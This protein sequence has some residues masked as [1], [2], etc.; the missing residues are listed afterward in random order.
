MAA[1]DIYS[2]NGQDYEMIIRLY[3]SVNDVKL[4]NTAWED[5]F[6][7]EDIFDWK[8][9]GSITIKSP[10]ESFERE[11]RQTSNVI[12]IPKE[13]LVYKFRNDGRDTIFITIKPVLP[14]NAPV[15]IGNFTDKMWRL[16]IEGVIYDVEDLP[17]ENSTEK[18]KKLY[19]HEK[20]YQMMTEK[21]SDF[22]TAT[23]GA[24]RSKK[25]IDQLS[26]DAKSL[27]SGDALG[28]LLKSDVDFKK[29]S[30]LVGT[31]EW[32][33][34]NANCK[35]FYSSPVGAKFIDDM[36]YFLNY[37]LASETYDSQPC[38]FKFE[39][40]D[41]TLTPKQ[42]SLKPI[43]KYFE[44]AGNAM[45]QEYQNEHFFIYGYSDSDESPI[46]LRKAPLNVAD[47]QR[48]IKSDEQN[49]IRGYQLVDLSGQ[50]YAQNLA[51]YRVTSFNSTNGQFNE[52]G[53]RHTVQAYKDFFNKSIKP[54]ILTQN[55]ED[56]LALTPFIKNNLNT[57][58]VYSLRIDENARLANG[59]NRMLKYYLFSNLAISFSVR[60]S[61]HRQTGRF[62]GLSKQSRNTQEF[63]N[64][65]E[66]QYFVTNVIHYFSNSNRNYVNQLVGV[67]THTYREFTKFDSNDA[68]I[69]E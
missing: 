2:F 42:F 1:E 45:P 30:K 44:K 13:K 41:K 48:E 26:N 11:S 31:E 33:V 68:M 5:L 65:L 53:S 23:A 47:L 58:T 49:S 18:F 6:L 19:F 59:R 14:P 54:F 12:N 38:I 66:G 21:D 32:D 29:H 7:E 25:K 17:N 69:I 50:D 24:N 35:S 64:K 63:D 57:K 28:E 37:A 51:N 27:T 39:R 10:H 43:Q 34:G 40:A 9:K 4:T 56:R 61:S 20:T 52:E 22:S 15:A 55:E 8:L 36:D 16:E 3:N 67:K 46:V 60:G 62:F